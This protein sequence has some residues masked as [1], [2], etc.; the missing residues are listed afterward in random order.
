MRQQSSPYKGL[1]SGVDII[2]TCR[3][4]VLS[5]PFRLLCLDIKQHIQLFVKCR[6]NIGCVAL[7]FLRVGKIRWY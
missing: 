3:R 7:E 6:K 4:C 5:S 1:V 2:I